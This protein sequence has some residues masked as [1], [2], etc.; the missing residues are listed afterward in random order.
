M[1]P[2][3]KTGSIIIVKPS[4]NYKIGDTITFG[5]TTKTETPTTH[6]IFEIV[7]EKG[8]PIYITKGDANQAPDTKE[9]LNKDIIG[10][11]LFDAPYIGYV[12]DAAKKPIGFVVIIIV[13]AVIIISDE[14]RKIWR[15]V[16]KLKNKKKDRDQDKEIIKLK[17]EVE[18][19]R[20][21]VAEAARKTKENNGKENNPSAED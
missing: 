4:D 2:A 18:D 8:E 6:R 12:V 20:N 19:L 1:E 7:V 13:P 5:K 21:N 17:Q 3:I 16:K 14:L 10:K 9:V 15:E 11:V